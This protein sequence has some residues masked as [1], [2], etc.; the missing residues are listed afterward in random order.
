MPHK[1]FL[2]LVFH[3]R[4]SLK[5]IHTSQMS[6]LLQMIHTLPSVALAHLIPHQ[7]RHHALNPLLSNNRILRSLERLIVLVV[8]TIEGRRNLWL[9]GQKHRGLGSWHCDGGAQGAGR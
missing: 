4:L 1:V 2:P 3:S 9:L 7:P 8:N 5:D 6:T